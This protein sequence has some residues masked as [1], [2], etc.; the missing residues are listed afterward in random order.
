[1]LHSSRTMPRFPYHAPQ[2][3]LRCLWLFIG[4]LAVT[5]GCAHAPEIDTMLHEAP[6][7]SVYLERIPDRG[8]KAAHPI[9]IDEAIIVR[10]L[11]GVRVTERKTALQT[12]FSKQAAISRAFSEDD[13][14]FLA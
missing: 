7:G 12:A 13:I 8:F 5:S 11:S 10:T 3:L 14:R 1:M 2:R 6:R 4:F 9:S